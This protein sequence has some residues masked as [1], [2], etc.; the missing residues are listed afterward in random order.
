M[1]QVKK[2]EGHSSRVSSVAF[3]PDG[4]LVVS[5]GGICDGTVRIWSVESGSEVRCSV[6][7]V[8]VVRC[9]CALVAGVVDDGV[10]HDMIHV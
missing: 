5:A 4:K 6:C 1:L 9:V 2:L 3:S 10:D 7:A 8:G